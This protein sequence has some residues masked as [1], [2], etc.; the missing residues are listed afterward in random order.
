MLDDFDWL[1][2]FFDV[3]D[4]WLVDFLLDYLF[5]FDDCLLVVDMH[6]LPHDVS[7]LLLLHFDGN[8]DDDLTMATAG[9]FGI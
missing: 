5:F 3:M 9:W 7:V 1:D 6:G 8:V 4:F 2:D